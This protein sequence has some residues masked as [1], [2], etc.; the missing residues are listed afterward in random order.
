MVF[1]A[2]AAVS[3]FWSNYQWAT[4]GSVGYLFAYTVLGVAVALLRDTIQIVRAF[5]DVLRFALIASIVLEILSGL[6]IDAP[7]RFLGITGNLDQLGPIQGIVGTRN[8]LGIIAIIALVTFATEQRT[9]SVSR[10]LSA[11]S[12][13][14]AALCLLLSQSPV[15][16]G[17]TVVIAIA[18]A[19]LY[20]LRRIDPGRQRFWQLGLLGFSV[21]T[22]VLA[23][24]FRDGI[25]QLLDA[26]KDLDYR[27]NLW[28]R[29]LDL[30]SVHSLEGWGWIGAWR[31]DLV[32]YVSFAHF[33]GGVPG[34]ALNAFFDTWLQLGLAGLAALLVLV[35]LAFARSWL[36]ASTR[37][38]VVFT[39][40]ALVLLTL[41]STALAESSLLTEFGWLTL[42]VCT[43]KASRELSWRQAFASAPGQPILPHEPR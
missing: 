6:L 37:R 33:P 39:W 19:A 14:L 32:P 29:I 24:V 10:G 11:A 41:I 36:L 16:I 23:W 27:L 2:W 40:P 42:V 30:I 4:L 5:G 17:T 34:T 18:T 15:A 22:V 20:G 35:V 43:V 25:I 9:R 28:R 26:T 1:V 31:G 21:V 12:L 38:S 3:V 7:I 8:Q 13:V